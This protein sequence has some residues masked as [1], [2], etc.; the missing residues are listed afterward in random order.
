MV[1]E[2]KVVVLGTGLFF[3]FFLSQVQ[4]P[5][6]FSLGAVGKSALTIQF[7]QGLFVSKYDPTIEDCY[8][9][10]MEVNGQNVILEILDTAGTDSFTAMRDI[11][12]KE[13][14][15]FIL[16]YSLVAKSSWMDLQDIY[17]QLT[18]VR[19]SADFPI[20]LVGNK[21]D[22]EDSRVISQESGRMRA[23]E[24]KADFRE[25]SAMNNV[26][27]QEVFTGLVR[28]ILQEREEKEKYQKQPKSKNL[29]SCVLL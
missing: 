4:K 22:L 21:C 13:G 7:V 28:R 18:R 11:Y 6:S 1:H 23:S 12:M 14:E 25:C 15:G 19:D 29:K 20:T 9:K 16:V 5:Y 2:L 26:G 3:N 27:V 24:W 8:R 17:E 10:S